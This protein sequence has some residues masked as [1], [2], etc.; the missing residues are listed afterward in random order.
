[1][2]AI[3]IWIL[4][5]LFHY[6]IT[7]HVICLVSL[8]NLLS[9][10]IFISTHKKTSFIWALESSYTYSK[11]FMMSN[12][13]CPF[14]FMSRF[15]LSIVTSNIIFIYKVVCHNTC[16]PENFN[17]NFHF[18]CYYYE[19]ISYC[20]KSWKYWYVFAI[21]I[22]EQLHWKITSFYTS[23]KQKSIYIEPNNRWLIDRT[24]I[25]HFTKS[26]YRT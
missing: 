23:S 3:S 17:Q 14:K 12:G 11:N 8:L 5:I 2:L 13:W 10:Y 18:F 15:L 4:K 22:I 25:E 16:Y 1:M 7:P 6:K 24:N 9:P 21:P 26:R 20:D 19:S